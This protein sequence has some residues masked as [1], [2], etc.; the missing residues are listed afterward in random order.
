[1]NATVRYLGRRSGLPHSLEV[2]PESDGDRLVIAS[3]IKAKAVE[4]GFDLCPND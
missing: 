2:E 1:M 4:L 3:E